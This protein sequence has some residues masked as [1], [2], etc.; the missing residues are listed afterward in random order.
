MLE[1]RIGAVLAHFEMF[2]GDSVVFFIADFGGFHLE[3]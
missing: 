2:P 3:W 1:E